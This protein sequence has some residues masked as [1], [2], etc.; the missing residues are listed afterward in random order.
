MN[1]IVCPFCHAPLGVNELEK[2]TVDGHDGLV[3]PEC[4]S[5]LITANDGTGDHPASQHE[6]DADA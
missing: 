5:V 3:C 2:A 6:A 4:A 1:R